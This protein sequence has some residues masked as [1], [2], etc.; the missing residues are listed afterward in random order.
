MSIASSQTETTTIYINVDKDVKNDAD[1]LFKTM[2]INLSSAVDMFLRKALSEQAIPFQQ[3]MTQ[4]ALP[5]PKKTLTERIEGFA[6]T[7]EY[8]ECDTGVAV[9]GEIIRDVYS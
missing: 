8:T 5:K 3:K 4:R 7:Y 1:K 6:N 2:G 9:G